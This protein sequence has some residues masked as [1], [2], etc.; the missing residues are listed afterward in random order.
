MI[1]WIRSAVQLIRAGAWR[2]LWSVIQSYWSSET[3]IIGLR[4]DIAVP[5]T[6]PQAAI[7]IHVRPL[8]ESDVPKLFAANGEALSGEAL[9]QRSIRQRMAT[10][11]LN[12]C[13]VAATDND[14]PCYVQWL[15]GSV[16]NER[17]HSFFGDRF[18]RLKSDEMLL[19][20]A[21]TREAWRGKGVM[22]AAMARIA[23]KAADHDARWVITFVASD[24]IPS[25]KGCKK[26]G[27]DPY[28]GRT[29]RWRFFRLESI[30]GAIPAPA[31]RPH[32][33]EHPVL[34]AVPAAQQR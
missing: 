28:I 31:A 13:Y 34:P 27:F 2:D 11:G 19:E 22:A 33:I 16:D 30:F 6:A 24:N 10:S 17:I 23:E 32:S 18:P 14:E 20:G 7:P 29:D 9:R 21:F 3:E 12:S 8:R 1:T 5:F 15:I 25:L 4:R 26:S